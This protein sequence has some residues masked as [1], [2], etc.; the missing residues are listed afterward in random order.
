MRKL[1][2]FPLPKEIDYEATLINNAK[3]GLKITYDEFKLLFP[4]PWTV[5]RFLFL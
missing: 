4:D 3:F 2:S 5:Q 1:V